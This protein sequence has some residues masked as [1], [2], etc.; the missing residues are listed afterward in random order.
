MALSE[1]CALYAELLA[2]IRQISLAAS[3]PSP[4]NASTVVSLASD[5]RTVELK[6][7][8]NHARQLKLPVK[9]SVGATLLPIADKER[10]TALLSW[11]L[12][13]DAASLSPAHQNGG[14]PWSAADLDPGAGVACRQCKVDVVSSNAVQSWKDLPSENWAE[15]M[16]FWHCHKP[17]HHHSHQG[18]GKADEASLAAR[19]YG[20]SSVISAQEG[21]G[22]VDL[23]TL[24]FA[25]SDCRNITVSC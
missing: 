18:S 4:S 7:G 22:F 19:G 11:R 24:L 20:A 3:L 5:G 12:P 9:A 6:H 16:E 14:I 15:M 1:E 25:E 2:N 23:T 10:G 8:T 21:V 13:V 17:D